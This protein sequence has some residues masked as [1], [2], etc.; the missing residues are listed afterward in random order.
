LNYITGSLKTHSN[1]ATCHM[2]AKI[3][4]FSTTRI[5]CAYDNQEVF[6]GLSCGLKGEETKRDKCF[7][8][9]ELKAINTIEQPTL[10]QNENKDYHQPNPK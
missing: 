6:H 2:L 7:E 8:N 4:K 1:E 9:V 5:Q 10:D 3:L